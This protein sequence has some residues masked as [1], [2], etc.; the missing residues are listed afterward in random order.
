MVDLVGIAERP[1]IE[2]VLMI[3]DDLIQGTDTNDAIIVLD[4]LA[5]QGNVFAAY[6]LGSCYLF[7]MPPRH[8]DFNRVYTEEQITKAALV[9]KDERKA[10][11]YYF[12]LLNFGD[13]VE[14]YQLEGVYDLYRILIGTAPI[15]KHF[16]LELRPTAH[17]EPDDFT[18]LFENAHELLSMLK[19]FDYYESYIDIAKYNMALFNDTK[20]KEH[21]DTAIQYLNYILKP[22]DNFFTQADEK[23]ATLQFINIYLNGNEYIPVDVAKAKS[24]AIQSHSDQALL[25]ILNYFEKNKISDVG[26]LESI[27]SR[28]V[29]NSIRFEQRNRFNLPY[30]ESPTD[31]LAKM[32]SLFGMKTPIMSDMYQSTATAANVM[33]DHQA[34]VSEAGVKNPPDYN[35]G[36]DNEESA[37]PEEIAQSAQDAQDNI[38]MLLG[39][40]DEE[41]MDTISDDDEGQKVDVHHEDDLFDEFG[42]DEE[43]DDGLYGYDG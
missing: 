24:L 30:P 1:D 37:S 43:E 36:G 5:S 13:E 29:D 21:L 16:N 20:N 39:A 19:E 41:D 38:R 32:W 27:L 33:K 11:G 14:R 7:G 34:G 4:D 10:F 12:Q 26:E 22:K 31:R 2:R 9:P 18:V 42:E 23:E 8:Y 35:E 15:F 28:I 40:V 3:Y 25:I 6:V 17:S